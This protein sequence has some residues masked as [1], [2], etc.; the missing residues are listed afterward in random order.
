MVIFAIIL[1]ILWAIFIRFRADRCR[2]LLI[3]ALINEGIPW[4]EQ[5][6]DRHLMEAAIQS[7]SDEAEDSDREEQPP[8][9]ALDLEAREHG[10]NIKQFLRRIRLLPKSYG[11]IVLL[12]ILPPIIRLLCYV[13]APPILIAILANHRL[14]TTG[15]LLTAAIIVL[16]N[17]RYRHGGTRGFLRDCFHALRAHLWQ[18]TTLIRLAHPDYYAYVVPGG[19]PG[20]FYV[21][22]ARNAPSQL[23]FL[24]NFTSDAALTD[25][26]IHTHMNVLV[27]LFPDFLVRATVTAQSLGVYR[28]APTTL[29][30]CFLTDYGIY[31]TLPAEFY[32]WRTRST[33]VIDNS[34]VLR[35]HLHNLTTIRMERTL[36]NEEQELLFNVLTRGL[37]AVHVIRSSAVSSGVVLVDVTTGLNVAVLLQNTGDFVPVDRSY[38]RIS[39][40]R[41][42][43]NSTFRSWENYLAIC[44]GNYGTLVRSSNDYDVELSN[45]DLVETGNGYSMNMYFYSNDGL[46]LH[47]AVQHTIELVNLEASQ[48]DYHG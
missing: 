47:A 23:A 19:S 15:I 45:A 34:R 39:L 22:K 36:R 5:P 41:G 48:G 38:A 3:N 27:K 46:R 8:R 13:I 16:Q 42:L 12:T 11:L 44:H 7:S 33:Y 40:D 30:K 14:A 10:T 24:I 37:M 17:P 20:Q 9:D 21:A 1:R 26:E 29:Y 43:V 25:N 32:I 28:G 18:Q 2:R 4:H 6:V 31:I 35:C